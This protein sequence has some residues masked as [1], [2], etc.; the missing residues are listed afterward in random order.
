MNA[1]LPNWVKSPDA[2]NYMY[3]R[4]IET[5]S[6]RTPYYYHILNMF[7]RMGVHRSI[8]VSF[9]DETIFRLILDVNKPKVFL[10][11]GTAAGVSALIASDYS[12]VITIDKYDFPTKYILWNS[13]GVSDKIQP[14]LTPTEEEKKAT[15]DKLDFDL[16]FIDAVHTYE[17]VKADFELVK[18]CGKVLFHDYMF[19]GS[20]FERNGH[21]GDVVCGVKKFVDELPK[22]EV[23][24]R[25]PFAFWKKTILHT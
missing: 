7:G 6:K 9:E 19:P 14:L 8:L 24:I 16:A 13:F 11:I 5:G 15:I 17:G 18:R 2:L 23:I 20:E 3:G 1:L 22:D 10:E 25:E 12:K 21:W 4:Y